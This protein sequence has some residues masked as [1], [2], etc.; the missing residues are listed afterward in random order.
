MHI[1]SLLKQAPKQTLPW[2]DRDVSWLLFNERLLNESKNKK[3]PLLERVK[4]LSIAAAHLDELMMVRVPELKHKHT[5]SFYQA[6]RHQINQLRQAQ[7]KHYLTIKRQLLKERIA[8]LS[9]SQ[10]NAQDIQFLQD[11][12]H[13]HVQP[14]LQVQTLDSGSLEALSALQIALVMRVPVKHK[15]DQLQLIPLNMEL[16]RFVALPKKAPKQNQDRLLPLEHMVLLFLPQV[17]K[18][19]PKELKRLNVQVSYMRVIHA[20]EPEIDEDDIRDTLGQTTAALS[21]FA[22]DE[23]EPSSNVHVSFQKTSLYA[24]LHNGTKKQ[25]AALLKLKTKTHI[26]SLP[27]PTLIHLAQLGKIPDLILRDKLKD[28]PHTPVLCYSCKPKKN[29]KQH[30]NLFT[31]IDQQDLL[32]HHPYQSFDTV[33]DLLQTAA[34][35]PHVHAIYQTL[36]RTNLDSPIVKALQQAAKNGKKVTVLI[37]LKAR[38]DEAKNLHV[39]R[40]LSSDGIYVKFGDAHLKTHAKL[41]CIKRQEKQKH[42]RSKF[43]YYVHL[44]TGNYNEKTARIYTDFSLFTAHP[45]IGQEA[46]QF[47]RM[48]EQKSIKTP[49]FSHL[50]VAPLHLRTFILARIEQVKRA[51]PRGVIIA[52][53]NAL[54]D[55]QVIEALY[56]ASQAGA[57]ITLIVRGMCCLVPQQHGVSDNIHVYSLVDRFLE[58]RRLFYFKDNTQDALYL[59]SADWRERNFDRRVEI[60]FPVYDP[61]IKDYILNHVLKSTMQDNVKRCELT[62][63]GE[64]VSIQKQPGEKSIRSQEQ[65]ITLTKHASRLKK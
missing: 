9:A 44:G 3:A 53:L 57:Q 54:M 23:D 39:A 58:H 59:S 41:I 47:F 29:K 14:S 37:E 30:C 50:I 10:M 60:A 31:L 24:D 25:I 51:G 43:K 12:M 17:L 49:A 55:K 45:E 20:Y 40:A 64:Y 4:F 15:Q 16:P 2:I 34:Q 48:F 63:S 28:T 61:N 38:F 65:L 52:Q 22:T 21:S 35:D 13:F 62:A 8:V 32:L 26:Q 33:I 19:S 1:I 46:M 6:L 27:E 42:G 36:Y 56:Q 5:A 7:Q 18:I 11:Y